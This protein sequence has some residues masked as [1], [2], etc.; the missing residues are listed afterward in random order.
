MATDAAPAP[1]RPG[2]PLTAETRLADVAAVVTFGQNDPAYDAIATALHKRNCI[3]LDN[4]SDWT[5][6]EFFSCIKSAAVV[7]KKNR[8]AYLS[9]L[10]TATQRKLLIERSRILGDQDKTAEKKPTGGDMLGLSKKVQASD[11]FNPMRWVPDP[12]VYE[13]IPKK[14]EVDYLEKEHEELLLDRLWLALQACAR[15][16]ASPRAA[17]HA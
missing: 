14:D 17:V 7:L 15:H 3:T 6:G 2:L 16:N 9:A 12:I 13:G 10:E 1:W 4:W 5:K 8:N 11:D